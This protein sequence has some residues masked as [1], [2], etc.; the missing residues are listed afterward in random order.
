MFIFD[1]FE[2]ENVTQGFK[3]MGQR[4]IPDSYIFQQLVHDKVGGR[5]FPNGLDVFSVFGSPRAAYYMQS[6]NASYPDYS[7]QILKLRKE[8]GNLTDYIICIY[9]KIYHSALYNFRS[10]DTEG[11]FV[12]RK[13]D[14]RDDHLIIIVDD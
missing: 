7:D 12:D 9:H 2:H 6:E 4:F 14:L 5:L 1:A 8:F 10:H 3:L 13:G 11:N